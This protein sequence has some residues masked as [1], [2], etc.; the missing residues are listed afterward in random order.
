MTQQTARQKTV[1]IVG[2]VAHRALHDRCRSSWILSLSF[3]TP[4]DL[5]NQ[6]FLPTHWTWANYQHRLQDQPLHQ[7]AAQLDRHRDHL[8]G[9]QRGVRHLRRV[10]HRPARVSRQAADP[11]GRA[12]DRRLPGGVAGQPAVQPVA[13]HRS[14]RHLAGRDHPAGVVLAAAVDLRAVRLLPGDPLGD[15]AGRSGR[16]RH[17]LAGLPQGPRPAGRR[18]ASSPP[19]S[20]RSSPD[21]TTSSSGS[22]S[23]PPSGPRTVPAA[24]AFFTGASQFQSPITAIAAA[25]VVVTVPVIIMVLIFQR[26]IVAGLTNGAVKG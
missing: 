10:R 22:P 9:D 19:P 26:R 24:M 12:G 25:A 20:W 17:R 7:R 1:W 21:G 5:T 13:Q 15:G 18:P 2:A 3:K 11:V 4:S 14:V 8:H 16:R 23:P 6:S